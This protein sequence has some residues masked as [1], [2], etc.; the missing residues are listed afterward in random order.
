MRVILPGPHLLSHRHP[1]R[2]LS[3]YHPATPAI[4][5]SLSSEDGAEKVINEFIG[6]IV[7]EVSD[8]VTDEVI[9][10]AFEELIVI[11]QNPYKI[12][13]KAISELAGPPETLDPEHVVHICDARVAKMG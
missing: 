10:E 2:R 9:D 5:F 6:E 7:I 8:E 13:S 12:M 4:P 11:D 1:F 3:C